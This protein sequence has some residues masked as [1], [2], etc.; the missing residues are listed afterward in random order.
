MP[1]K[2][3]PYFAGVGNESPESHCLV[4]LHSHSHK[5]MPGEHLPGCRI[6]STYFCYRKTS[7]NNTIQRANDVVD[8]WIPFIIEL[9]RPRCHLSGFCLLTNGIFIKWNGA[10][11][12]LSGILVLIWIVRKSSSSHRA[13][14]KISHNW[15]Y[16]RLRT[17]SSGFPICFLPRGCAGN[18]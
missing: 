17:H 18:K 10:T 11:R 16:P 15:K 5:D 9:A 6:Q 12:P 4:K 7:I 3:W 8:I 14:K 1:T 13:Q 2:W